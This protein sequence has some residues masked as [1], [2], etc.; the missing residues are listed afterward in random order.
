MFRVGLGQDSHKFSNDPARKLF[1]AGVE[2]MGEKGLL[3]NSDADVII[4]SL[5][6]AL[7]QAIGGVSFFSYSDKMRRQGILES[8]EYLMVAITH[9]KEVGYQINNVGISLECQKPKISSLKQRMRK[10]LAKL[11]EISERD[12]GISATSGEELTAFGRGEGIQS[13]AIVSLIKKEND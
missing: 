11:L 13:L 1:L 7:E 3:G 8:K 2:I 9:V 4:H 6:R 5:C 12:I 10:K